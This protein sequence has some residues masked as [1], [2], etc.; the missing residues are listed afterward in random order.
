VSRL[1]VLERGPLRLRFAPLGEA[2]AFALVELPSGGSAGTSL[3]ESCEQPHWG[4][5]LRGSVT[6]ERAGERRALPAGTAFHIPAGEPE[7]RMFADG[8]ASIAGF[9]RI[10]DDPTSDGGTSPMIVRQEAEIDVLDGRIDVDAARMGSWVM[11]R[12]RFG[13]TSGWVSP[14]C[15]AEHFGIVVEGDLALEWEGDVE[16]LAAGDV[17]HCPAGPPGHRFVV[18]DS[19]TMVDFTP[20]SALVDGKRLADWRR[21]AVAA[22]RMPAAVTE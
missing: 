4:F 19:A 21:R 15:D 6:V 20:V 8:E 11:C 16:V 1:R 18:A 14:W 3:E 10:G 2:V 12:A 7:H 17:Y 13:R 9:I 5:V 22:Y